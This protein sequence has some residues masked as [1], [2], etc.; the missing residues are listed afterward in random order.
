MMSM[1]FMASIIASTREGAAVAVDGGPR[2]V[3]RSAHQLPQRRYVGRFPA[4]LGGVALQTAVRVSAVGDGLAHRVGVVGQLPDCPVG[5]G[6]GDGFLV[7]VGV[8]E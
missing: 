4:H 5:L 7:V 1:Y 8:G 6:V 2:R 3:R